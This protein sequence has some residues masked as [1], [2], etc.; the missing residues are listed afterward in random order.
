MFRRKEYR[1]ISNPVCARA[2][3]NLAPEDFR[4]YDKD[5]FEL[6]DAEHQY[7]HAMHYP[8]DHGILN[9][10][11]WQEPWFE[12]E[13]NDH[14]ILD[15]STFLCRCSY[16]D[17]ALDQLKEIGKTIPNAKWLSNTKV[18][19]GFDFALDA[20]ANDQIY[21]VLHIEYDSKNFDQ[22]SEEI[23][24]TEYMIRHTDWKDAAAKVWNQRNH[25]QGLTGF[26]QN[27]WKAKYLLGWSLSEF[28]EKST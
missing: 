11:S 16:V 6:N 15:H 3:D 26:A 1:F 9:H 18:K 17:A 19:W 13:E 27:S 24:R 2:V 28:T 7:Y 21:E 23:I 20:V 4:W 12:I 5:G 10:T 14:L 25:C 22:F 8:V